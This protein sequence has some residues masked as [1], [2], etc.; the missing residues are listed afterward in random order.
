MKKRRNLDKIRFF[1][2][3][4]KSPPQ[5]VE[6]TGYTLIHDQWMRDQIEINGHRPDCP[7]IDFKEFCKMLQSPG[8]YWPFTCTC[9]F[10][11]DACIHFP[12]RCRH[13]DDLI[14]LVI[15]E[16]LRRIPPCDSC[17]KK[18]SDCPG[19]YEEESCPE[20]HFHY[21]AFRFRKEEIQ[22]G[23]YSLGVICTAL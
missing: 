23:L 8:D 2:E 11:E 22:H 12:V 9:G 17:N 3:I 19:W 18:K 6:D 7:A 1:R 5:Y 4:A 20:P 13:K 10:P 21:Q 15:R 14:I 16:P